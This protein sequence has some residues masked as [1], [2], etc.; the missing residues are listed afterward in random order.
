MESR[1]LKDA[2]QIQY[3]NAKEDY[4]HAPE[5][6]TREMAPLYPFVVS[7]GENT[8]RYYFKHVSSLSTEY[9]FNVRPEYFG[10]ESRYIEEFPPRIEDILS[11]NE[12]AKIFC[13]FD[14]DTIVKYKLEDKHQHFIE[15][16]KS[17]IASGQVT[18]CESMPSF[19][20]WLLLHFR[21]YEGLLKDYTEVSAVL[22]QYIKPCFADP[23]PKLKKLLKSEKYLKDSTW[24]KNLLKDDK[25]E[26]AIGRAKVC[27]Q[28]IET[29]NEP[30]SYS[31]VFKA[32]EYQKE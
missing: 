5:E 16:L 1:E 20:F 2:R 30:Q 23:T 21:D 31:N 13:V 22:A 14:M 32:F 28:R 26:Q 11:K 9:K 6:G 7:G 17:K 24:V 25:L 3:F 27:A 19:E 18:I 12:G 4:S 10:N 8:E 29:G 15:S